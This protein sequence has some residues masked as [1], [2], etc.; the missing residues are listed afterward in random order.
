MA[1][2]APGWT[3]PQQSNIFGSTVGSSSPKKFTPTASSSKATPSKAAPAK[4]GSSAKVMTW[5]GRP[6][7]TPEL[8]VDEAAAAVLPGWKINFFGKKK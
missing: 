4:K 2:V 8:Y 6:D 7:P 1:S 5:G 3:M